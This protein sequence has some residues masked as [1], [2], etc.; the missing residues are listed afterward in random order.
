MDTYKVKIKGITPLSTSKAIV[1]EKESKEQ[2][3]EFEKRCWIERAHV[4]E[5]GEC[6]MPAMAF[7]NS[8]TEAAKY[9][10]LKVPGKRNATYTKHFEAGVYVATDLM[11]GVKKEDIKG[12]WVFVPSDGVR[13]GGKRVW[14]C[15]PVFREWGGDVE[16]NVLDETITQEALLEHVRASGMFRG[17]GRF[18]PGSNGFYG[19]FEVVSCKRV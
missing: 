17:V 4:D 2:P 3:A 5:K 8:V 1:S 16:Y 9:L 7:K 6:F 11:L 12:E 18:R 10:S 13:G 14:K 15:F 19:R